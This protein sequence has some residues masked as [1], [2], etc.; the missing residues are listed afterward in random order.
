MLCKGEKMTV[1]YAEKPDLGRKIA[2]ALSDKAHKRDKYIELEYKGEKTV[3][4]WGFGHMYGLKDAK[5]YD[6]ALGKWSLALYPYFPQ[7]YLISARKDASAQLKVVNEWL[8]K[9]DVIVNAADADREGEL[10]FSY[11]VQGADVRSTPVR[12]L[13]LHSYMPED[14]RESYD[15]MRDGAQMRNLELAARTRA[16]IDWSVGINLTIFATKLFGE[17]S[18][19]KGVISIGRVQT[20]TLA[21]LVSR[22]LAIRDFVSKPFWQVCAEFTCETGK[23]QGVLEEEKLEDKAEAERICAALAQNPRGEVTSVKKTTEKSAAPK[24]YNLSALQKDANKRFGYTAQQT[25]DAAQQLY[26]SQFITYPRSSSQALPES[27]K[28]S[29]GQTIRKLFE[30]DLFSQY[31]IEEFA[32]FTK[33]HFN[34]KEVESHYAIIPTGKRPGQLGQVQMNVYRLIALSLIRIAYPQAVSEKTQVVTR[35]AEYNFKSSGKTVISAGWMAV[36]AMPK[37]ETIIPPLEKGT[38]VTGEFSLKEGKT[39]PPDRY[40]DATL[41]SAMANAGKEVDDEEARRMLKECGIG[42]EATRA[43]ILETLFSRGYAVRQ[44]KSIVPT[45]KGI[46]LIAYLPVETLKSPEMTGKMEQKLHAIENGEESVA[47]VLNQSRREVL[48]WCDT[49]RRKGLYR[50]RFETEQPSPRKEKKA[51]KEKTEARYSCLKCGGAITV[52]QEKAQCAECGF[53][54]QRIVGGKKMTDI[55]LQKL[56]A[57]KKVKAKGFITKSGRKFG[58]T[59]SLDQTGKINYTLD[60]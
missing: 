51:Q 27:M 55:Q 13:W 26:E 59:I 21:M 46:E 50:G 54:I 8:K 9:A 52:D 15:S 23:Y 37:K 10:I 35:V 29:V 28:K 49:M 47:A 42:T 11:V 34:D 14:I 48:D 58:A 31:R 43:S 53:G 22:E 2:A 36:D 40:T 41:I 44:G 4:V 6:P 24:L 12:R 16:C 45:Q 57:G 20:P 30:T 7:R 39:E 5:E 38:Q 56:C 1:I 17:P 3:V 32:S 18:M 25:L 33:R 19:T 60:E